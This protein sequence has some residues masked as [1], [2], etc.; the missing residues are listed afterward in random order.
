MTQINFIVEKSLSAS[1]H[2]RK[3]TPS[4]PDLS[5]ARSQVFMTPSTPSGVSKYVLKHHTNPKVFWIV[6][7]SFMIVSFDRNKIIR[8][9]RIT[10]SGFGSEWEAFDTNAVKK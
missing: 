9:G 2:L 7:W 6:C 1:I 3:I 4:A 10:I 5:S 8:Y